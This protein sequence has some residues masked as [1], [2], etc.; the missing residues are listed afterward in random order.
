MTRAW[1]ALPLVVLAALAALFLGYALHH[2][3]RVTPAALV[4]QA[5]P[6]PVLTPLDGGAPEALAA[7]GGRPVL[8]N[9]FAS[10]CLP[11]AEEAPA[12]A[13]L[14]AQGVRILGVAYKDDPVE[15]RR[16]LQA[17]GDPFA[18]VQLDPDGRAGVDYG[19]SGFPESFL[20]DA[21]GLVVAKYVGALSP[22]QAD[23]IA[24]AAAPGGR[25]AAGPSSIR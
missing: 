14:K 5:A 11:C 15:T 4:G 9:F 7:G 3:P 22:D 19:V 20:V 12:L 16:F 13:A 17:R 23:A 21:T 2:D 10:W 6:R 1:A 8:V 18:A 24:E 25:A